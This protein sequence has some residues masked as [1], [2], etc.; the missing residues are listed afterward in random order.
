[1]NF[2][3]RRSGR[4][5]ETVKKLGLLLPPLSEKRRSRI[6]VKIKIKI[7]NNVTTKIYLKIK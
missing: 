7:K 1:M 4:K 5:N 2:S 6:K 3:K